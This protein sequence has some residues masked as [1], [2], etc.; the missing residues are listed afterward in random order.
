MVD[1]EVVCWKQQF[2]E[3]FVVNRQPIGQLLLRQSAEALSRASNEPSPLDIGGCVKDGWRI[4]LQASGIDPGIQTDLQISR[5]LDKAMN[6]RKECFYMEQLLDHLLLSNEL[7]ASVRDNDFVFEVSIRITDGGC[8]WKDEYSMEQSLKKMREM[9]TKFLWRTQ[10]TEEE[11]EERIFE[12]EKRKEE[13]KGKYN[14]IVF[15]NRSITVF[16][17]DALVCFRGEISCK[18]KS[19]DVPQEFRDGAMA[20][21]LDGVAE[22]FGE[23]GK[24]KLGVLVY[25][26]TDSHSIKFINE[27]K[28]QNVLKR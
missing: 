24:R 8:G 3:I 2:E 22:V 21:F 14:D 11:Y 6:I 26:E 20:M 10:L 28:A 13:E 9:F 17:R 27:A 15:E 18:A 23:S 1:E 7:H 25:E 12:Y 16:G 5:R 4:M 19:K